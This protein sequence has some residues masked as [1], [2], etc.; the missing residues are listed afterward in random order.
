M[1]KILGET[2]DTSRIEEALGNR[3]IAMLTYTR[4]S[5]LNL[6]ST[7]YFRFYILDLEYLSPART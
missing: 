7:D 2:E 1:L 4:R 3:N 5:I 6:F